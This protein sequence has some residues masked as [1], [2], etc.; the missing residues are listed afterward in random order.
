MQHSPQPSKAVR[1]ARLILV[2]ALLIMTALLLVACAT[3]ATAT[4]TRRRGDR[5]ASTEEAAPAADADPMMTVFGEKLP[6]GARPY[7]EQVYREGCDI[8]LNKTTVD[9]MVAVYQRYCSGDSSFSLALVDL[10][11]DFNVTPMAAE[12]WEVAEDGVTWTFHLRPGMMW[13]DDTPV[14]ANDWVETYRYAADPEHAWDFAWFY[15]GV[16]KNWDEAIAGEAPL[17]E[18]GVRAVDDLTLEGN[19][20]LCSF[21]AVARH[22]ALCLA[23]A[24]QGAGRARSVLQQRP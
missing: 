24:S 6:D 1:P 20:H 16:I 3:P 13:S 21:P 7:A 17:E 5:S 2:A 15:S 12:S 22:D 19:H 11:K 23:V 10:D 8:N 4:G 14:T 18:L 9:F